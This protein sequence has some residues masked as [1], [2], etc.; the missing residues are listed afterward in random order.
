MAMQRA[1]RL[2]SVA[3]VASLTVAGL[4]ACRSDPSVAAYVGDKQITESQVQ[5][6]IDQAAAE[7]KGTAVT[8]LGRAD[9]VKALLS[10]DVLAQVA[11]RHSVSLPSDLQLS[12]FAT[13]LKLPEK[14]DY[15]RLYATTQ[16]YVAALRNAIKDGPDPTDA[17]LQQVY[18][19]LAA[20]GEIQPGQTAAQFKAGLT[21]AQKQLL[22]VATSVRHEIT[23]VTDPMKIKVNP[24][25]QPAAISVLDLQT[26]TGESYPLVTAPLGPDETAPVIDA[27]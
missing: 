4:S 11:A 27:R 22:Q 3:V 6:V 19:T 17:E 24:R 2:A 23:E 21:D 9:V 16:G 26:Q 5:A 14:A 8:P 20:H 1:R 10:V 13:M 7:A 25:Y 18:D 12:Q 15:V